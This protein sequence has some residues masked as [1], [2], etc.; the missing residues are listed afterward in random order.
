MQLDNREA[1]T[2][3][4]QA[5]ISPVALLSGVGLLILSQ[6]NRFSRI[7][8]RLR[9]LARLRREQ[10]G[11]SKHL[12]QQIEIFHRRARVMRL[13]ISS[14]VAS[15]LLASVLVLALFIIAALGVDFHVLVLV[16]FALGLVGLITSLTLFLQDM[17]LSL[18]AVEA[19]L[20]V[21]TE[22]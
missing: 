15:A 21:H 1:L 22:N 6:T 5:S 10:G 12:D 3:V 20:L 17:R 2:R 11:A 8:D 13:A 9:E 7:T 16:L 14:A 19:E 18:Q 4:L